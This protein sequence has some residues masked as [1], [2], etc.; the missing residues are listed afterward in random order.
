MIKPNRKGQIKWIGETKEFGAGK[1]YGIRLTE[2]RGDC[3]GEWK[4]VR[5]FQCPEGFGVYTQLR[6]IV[7]KIDEDFDFMKVFI[8]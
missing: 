2:K 1:Y 3:D 7:K 8:I 5:F 4:E 6:N